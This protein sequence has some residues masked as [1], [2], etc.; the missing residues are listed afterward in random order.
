[1]NKTGSII[2]E[3]RREAG[4]TQKTLAEA[5][6]VTDK[7]VS[8][9]ERGICLPDVS[10]LPKLSLLLDADIDLLLP[11]HSGHTTASWAGVIDLSG[12]PGVDLSQKVYDKPMVYYMLVHFL[13]LNITNICVLTTQENRDYLNGETFQELG[14]KFCYELTEV[15]HKNLMIMNRPVFLFGSDLTHQ[16]QGAMVSNSVMTLVPEGIPPVFLFCPAEYATIYA[17]NPDYLFEIASS[18]TL[19]RGMVCLDMDNEDRLTELSVFIRMY[20]KNTG[21]KIGNVEEIVAGR[22]ALATEKSALIE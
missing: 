22:V 19:G 6:N 9:W 1:M 15:S 2:A 21:L 10:L 16:F 3:L 12:Y 5:L 17:K 7:A 18:K 11:S 8:K 13:L 20:Q 4:Y 14:I